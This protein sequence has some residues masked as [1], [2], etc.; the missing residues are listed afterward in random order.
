MAET[1][2]GGAAPLLPTDRRTTLPL[3]AMMAVMCYLAALT[4]ALSIMLSETAADWS[5]GLSGTATVQLMPAESKVIDEHIQKTLEILRATPGIASA[6]L[7][8]EA[9]T[10]SLLEPWLGTLSGVDDLPMPRLIAIAFDP[11]TVVDTNALGERVS[12]AVPGAMLDTHQAWRETL[13]GFAGALA[14]FAYGVLA[15]IAAAAAGAVIFATRAGL[16]THQEIVEVLHFVGARDSFIA[17]EFQRRFLILGLEAGVLGAVFA[18]ITLFVGE[19]ATGA[20]ATNTGANYLPA[21]SPGLGGYLSLVLVP[22]MAAL[23]AM[24]TA[25]VTVLAALGRMP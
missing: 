22:A 19:I 15:L 21:L 5:R 4:L 1:T 25:R 23:I 10:R 12:A 7:V 20:M 9:E 18:A 14:W 16:L 3:T 13:S 11:G 2:N 17:S 8:S 6:R 24:L